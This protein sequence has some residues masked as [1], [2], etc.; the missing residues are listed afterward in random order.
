MLSDASTVGDY[1]AA[2]PADRRQALELLRDLCTAE[3]PGFEETMR[4]G[5]PSYLRSGEVEIGFASH[6]GYISLYVLRRDALEA[7]VARL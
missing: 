1:I 3:L 5:M 2:A 6:K 4:Y 7:N